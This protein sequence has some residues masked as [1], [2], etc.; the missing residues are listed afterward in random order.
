MIVAH[1]ETTEVGETC[2]A[3][4]P[5]SV[6]FLL[7]DLL[8]FALVLHIIILCWVNAQAFK[9]RQKIKPGDGF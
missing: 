7:V 1:E 4:F 6:C 2:Q 8:C 5:H 3:C 9:L